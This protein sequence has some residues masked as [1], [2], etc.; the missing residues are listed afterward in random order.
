MSKAA[1]AKA[2]TVLVVQVQDTSDAETVW[3]FT[4][5]VT[6]D[7]PSQDRNKGAQGGASR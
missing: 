2:P 6:S 7:I 4:R 1:P 5:L 3:R